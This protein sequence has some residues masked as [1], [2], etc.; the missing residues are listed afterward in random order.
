MSDQMV[1]FV[2]ILAGMCPVSFLVGVALMM[3]LNY[4]VAPDEWEFAYIEDVNP[5]RVKNIVPP[6]LT[7]GWDIAG[8]VND[9]K[10]GRCTLTFKRKRR[11]SWL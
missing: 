2:A 7:G 9:E 8:I 1:V 6:M 3:I 11:R 4:Q 5:G 10:V